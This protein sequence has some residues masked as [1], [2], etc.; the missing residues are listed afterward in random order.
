MDR[1]TRPPQGPREG[2]NSGTAFVQGLQR[3]QSGHSGKAHWRPTWL[4][5]R[6]RSARACGAL[7]SGGQTEKRHCFSR[8]CPARETKGNAPDRAKRQRGHGHFMK[9]TTPDFPRDTEARCRALA[10][11]NGLERKRVEEREGVE[12]G[13]SSEGREKDKGSGGGW[14]AQTQLFL[15]R[16]GAVKRSHR[17]RSHGS[18]SRWLKSAVS[19]SHALRQ[20]L[21]LLLQAAAAG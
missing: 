7:T 15:L 19:A 8:Q 13:G 4:D 5:T 10:H 3:L 16:K 21:R 20:N 11:R 12:E 2:C 14:G 9:T 17:P 6:L 1:T 18:R